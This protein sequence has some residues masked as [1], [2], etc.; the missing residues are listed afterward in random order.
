MP[1]HKAAIGDI[2]EIETPAGLAYI[3][4]THAS[5]D[6]GQLVRVLPGL[7]RMRP[8][9]FAGL[10]KQRELYFVFYTLEYALRDHQ[11]QFV[12]HQPIPDSA[13]AYP[14]MRWTLSGQSWK[15]L[16]ASDPLT[17]EFHA[18]TPAIQTLTP[19]QEKLSIH[20]LWPH[21]VLVR[22]IA[23]GWIPERA[24]E[25]ELE[26]AAAA[27]ER[28]K[29]RPDGDESARQVMRHY[30]YFPRKSAAGRVGERLRN[31][32]FEVEVRKGADGRNWLALA[33][34]TPPAS[35]EGMEQ[36]RDE[37]EALAREFEGEY[38]GWELGVGA[39]GKHGNGPDAI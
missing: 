6:M 35:G 27:E 3:Q 9:D 5:L 25:L 21:A 33:K 22:K 37:M 26:D 24:H 10:A 36:L 17:L 2:F 39:N 15:I 32:G 12:A 34:K 19:E 11:T 29:N 30:L 7:F 8:T 38:D 13:Q 31:R 23:R 28:K 16:R 20:Q 1:K 18:R 4:Y 14:L